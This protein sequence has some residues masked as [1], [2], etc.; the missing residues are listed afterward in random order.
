MLKLKYLFENYDLAK[1]VLDH[2]EHDIDTLDKMLSQFRIS[3]NAIYPFCQGGE[4]C[5]LRLA[6]VN[7]KME[8]NITGELEFLHYLTAHEYPALEPI[9]A[10]TG[11][12]YLK[13]KTEWGAYY[14]SAF[15]KV[16][17]VQ[18][19]DTDMSKEVMYQYGKALGRL[20]SLSA[21]FT[22]KTKKWTHT[23]V[24]E[25]TKAALTEYNAP[26][27][28]FLELTVIRNE[29]AALPVRKDN[30]GLVHYDFEPD[31]VFYDPSSNTCAVIDFDD[32]MYHWY[33]LDL[34]QVFDCLGDKLSHAEL[35]PAKEAFINGYKTEYCYSEE[36][37]KLLP[38]MRRFIDLFS[39]ARLIRSV[40]ESFP[41]EPEWLVG[42]RK[43]L[44]IIIENLEA[45]ISKNGNDVI[46]QNSINWAV[47]HL[48]SKEYCF[49]CLGFVEDALERSNNIEIFGGDSAKESADMYEAYRNVNTP[50]AGTFVFYDCFGDINGE[51]RN[52]GH[53]GLSLE[54]GKVIHAWDQVRID[55]YLAIEKLTSAP[56]W[57]QPQF[58]GWVPLERILEGFKRKIY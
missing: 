35:Q 8:K 51:N 54:D 14:A 57:S 48:G 15:K 10:I 27:A 22:P 58:I 5:F 16:C 56:G 53:V 20:H 1:E 11:E 30:Y 25:W 28:A 12:W 4:L 38:I 18:I 26:A 33:A 42:L 32:S 44:N 55:H 6:P 43:K 52:W 17:G 21:D 45:G 29:L 39:Y 31:N 41:D 36:T 47:G 40:S 34:E 50:P 2:W 9:P 49:H 19:E 46:V 24:L 3:S 37:S 7:E 23:D 13:L